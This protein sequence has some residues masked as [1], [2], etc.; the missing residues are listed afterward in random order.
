MTEGVL[1]I[2]NPVEIKSKQGIPYFVGVSGQTAG[3]QHLC[4]HMIMIPP[5]GKAKPHLHA[6][7]ETAI[8]VLKGQV[9]THYGPRLRQSAVA[10]E[11]DFL[12]IAPNS[13]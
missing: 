11:G 6:D 2:H 8:Y 7:Y 12:Y 9:V 5:G 13:P 1:V 3:T 4:M 10:G